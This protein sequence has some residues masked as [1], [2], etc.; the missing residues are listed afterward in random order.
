MTC[1]FTPTELAVAF[2]PGT[3]FLLG[4]AAYSVWHLL[5]EL[6]HGPPPGQ[7]FYF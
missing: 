2:L 7:R 4:Y 6:R 1:D 5:A 3:L